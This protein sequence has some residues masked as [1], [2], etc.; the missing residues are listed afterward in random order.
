M[1]NT[2]WGM[3]AAHS[4]IQFKIRHMMVSTVTG[5][6]SKFEGSVETEGDDFT[7]ALVKISV[8]LASISTNNEQR[9]GHLLSSDFF[10][11]EKHPTIDITG[12]G[13]EKTGTDT[14]KF[15]AQVSMHGVSLPVPFKVEH[16]GI[17]KDP[18][19]MTRTGFTVE[20]K[21]NR[22]D[23]GMVWNS[24][25]EAGGVALSDEVKLMANFEFVKQ[26]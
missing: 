20:G 21:I 17:V 9:D 19:G 1:S 7:T 24:A 26:A 8:D 3:D 2:K 5:H 4:E 12:G 11:K 10:D 18:W 22:S 6:F 14:Y 16:G 23:F 25:L 13:M 15:T